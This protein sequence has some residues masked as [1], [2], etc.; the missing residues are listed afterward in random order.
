MTFLP[1]GIQAQPPPER[2][3]REDFVAGAGQ[4]IR[5]GRWANA[6]VYLFDHGGKTWVVK[7]FLPRLWLVRNVIGRFLT[8]REIN[9]LERLAGLPGVPQGAF[10]VDAFAL[11]YY[12]VRGRRLRGLPASALPADFFPALERNL[13]TMHARSGIAH[14]DLRNA[15]NI[16]VSESGAPSL[17]DFQSHLS[18]RW[19]P[20]PLRRFAEHVDCAAI[21][22]HWARRCPATLGPERR[23]VLDRINRL[24]PLWVLRG[25]LGRPRHGYRDQ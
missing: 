7:D 19:L 1:Q 5:K 14:L 6:N 9:G 4:C 15:A 25:Y 20:G 16:V 23:A 17:I 3:A 13:R 10:R 24:R 8:R 22:K 21:Y 12:F 11:A 18:M 2:F